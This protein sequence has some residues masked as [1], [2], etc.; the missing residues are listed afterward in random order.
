MVLRVLLG[1]GTVGAAIAAL[2]FAWVIDWGACE[3]GASEACDRQELAHLQLVVAT[4]ALIPTLAL[5]TSFVLHWRR[6]A[7]SL[8]GIT[9]TMYLTWAILADAAHHGWDDLKLVPF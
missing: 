4:V 5:A 2:G 1:I 3:S 6:T 8:L 7:L 9:A